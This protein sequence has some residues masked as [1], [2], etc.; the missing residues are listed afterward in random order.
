MVTE[1]EV[2][3]RGYLFIYDKILIDLILHGS[4]VDIYSYSEILNV[5]VLSYTRGSLLLHYSWELTNL[6]LT[7]MEPA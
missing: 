3:P 2:G 7:A 4:C 1:L 5:I 6:R